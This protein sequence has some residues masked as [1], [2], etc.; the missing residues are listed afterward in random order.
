MFCQ[1]LVKLRSSQVQ[2]SPSLVLNHSC[3]IVSGRIWCV[4]PQNR[5]VSISLHL[6]TGHA[7]TALNTHIG[8]YAW[9]SLPRGLSNA[10]AVLQAEMNRLFG[11]RFTSACAFI[12]TMPYSF[13]RQRKKTSS[14]YTM[15]SWVQLISICCCCCCCCFFCCHGDLR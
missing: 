5:Q 9:K 13:Q 14:P 4:I 10:P 11:P 3:V 6:H 2:R 7:M 12:W 1:H 8:K 15:P